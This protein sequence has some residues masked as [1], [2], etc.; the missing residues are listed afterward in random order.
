MHLMIRHLDGRLEDAVILAISADRMRI[1]IPNC[2]DTTE[3]HLA[4]GVWMNE[5][6]EPVEIEAL[7][8]GTDLS[9]VFA[10]ILPRVH[11]AS[12]GVS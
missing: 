6:H 1:S 8:S 3:L 11:T 12:F 10:E 2:D 7:I 5:N 4:Q 9:S